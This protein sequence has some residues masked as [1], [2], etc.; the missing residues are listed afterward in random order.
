MTFILFQA[1]YISQPSEITIATIFD[2][3]AHGDNGILSTSIC[4]CYLLTFQERFFIYLAIKG[5]I[6]IY[7]V[8]RLEILVHFHVKT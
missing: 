6:Q 2:V 4:L 3:I 1:K 5:L 7:V 8:Y